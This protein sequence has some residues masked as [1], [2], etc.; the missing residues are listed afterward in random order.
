MSFN[1]IK[2]LLKNEIGLNANT[3]GA[4]SIERAVGHRMDYLGL[5][6]EASYYAF[7][8]K[9]KSEIDALVE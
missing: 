3:V 4:S 2:K 7:I 1:N 6:S 8:C 5:T 9:D